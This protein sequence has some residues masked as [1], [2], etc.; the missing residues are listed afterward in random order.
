MNQQR[1]I[2]SLSTS[3]PA[4]MRWGGSIARRMRHF[5]IALDGK[6]T[7]SA[8]TDAL[9]LADL[10]VQ[11]LLVGALRDGDPL[12]RQCRIAAEESTG[13]L[14][15]FALSSVYTLTL[16]PIDGTRRYRDHAGNGYSIILTLQ[17]SKTVVYSLIFIPESGP[18][19]AW[20]EIS[21]N[22][23]VYG[24]D[25]PPIPAAQVLKSITPRTSWPATKSKKIYV[26]GFQK[27]DRAKAALVTEAGLE[28]IP[29]DD[30]A[31]CLYELLATGEY[32]GS[33]IHTPN[34]YDYP[35]SLHGA[36]VS[37]GDS[38]WVHNEKAVDFEQT[39]IDERAHIV[40]LPGI[41]ATSADRSV[42][43]TLC[44]LAHDWNRVRY[45]E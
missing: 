32:A 16:D 2:D 5:N 36:R 35:A 11:E 41:I 21:S 8:N 18:Y 19:G 44:Q 6:Q 43:K 28:G 1:L 10:T 33:L 24:P 14:D 45:A 12:F 7:G 38:V 40:R 34:I 22:G 26:N 23:I 37:G 4:V 9:T 30:C 27:H 17:T 29:G 13:D 42:L 20:I 25:D 3:L 15:C 31:G 39:W